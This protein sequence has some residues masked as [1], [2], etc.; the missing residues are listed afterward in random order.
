M[1]LGAIRTALE[2][3]VGGVTGL[4]VRWSERPQQFGADQILLHLRGFRGVGLD[5]LSETYDATTPLGAAWGGITGGYTPTQTGQRVATLEIRAEVQSQESDEDAL[6]YVQLVRDRLGLPSCS[7]ALHAA[8]AAIGAILMEPRELSQSRDLRRVSAAQM[9][10]E[11]NAAAAADGEPY[12]TIESFELTTTGVDGD[13]A[14]V[15]EVTR[16]IEV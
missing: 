10:V 14:T 4:P 7:D 2:T 3:W 1:D 6:Y 12:G 16:T 11:L 13:G 8:G 9:D 5:E 15:F